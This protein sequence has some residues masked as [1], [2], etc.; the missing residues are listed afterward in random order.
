MSTPSSRTEPAVGA[1]IPAMILPSVDLP[2]RDGTDDAKAFTGRETERRALQEQMARSRQGGADIVDDELALWPVREGLDVRNRDGNGHDVVEPA[3]GGE[4]HRE[5]LPSHDRPFN[6]R[7]RASK[8]Q[9]GG[10]DD[11]GTSALFEDEPGGRAHD[12]NLCQSPRGF[13][14]QHEDL[15]A[16]LDHLLLAPRILRSFADEACSAVEHSHGPDHVEV[17]DGHAEPSLAPRQRSSRPR[18]RAFREPVSGE[19]ETKQEKRAECADHAQ[20]G[21]TRKRTPRKSGVQSAS[22]SVE[23]APD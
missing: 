10:K 6:G 11:G 19:P 7:E 22:N 18:Q 9:G 1:E 20:Q 16:A 21:C 4:S 17:S 14:D 23:Q 3:V 5:C 15:I 12:Q 8:Q 13:G 2:E